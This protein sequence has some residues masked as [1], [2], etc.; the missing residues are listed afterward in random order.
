MHKQPGL[1]HVTETCAYMQI[2]RDF[3][4]ISKQSSKRKRDNGQHKNPLW[5][6]VLPYF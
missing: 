1:T 3:L 4:Y 2:Y 5:K 6:Q